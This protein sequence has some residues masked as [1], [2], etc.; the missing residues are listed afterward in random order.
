MDLHLGLVIVSHGANMGPAAVQNCQIGAIMEQKVSPLFPGVSHC[1]HAVLQ[2]AVLINL[3]GLFQQ[4]FPSGVLPCF[5]FIS[6][7]SQLP[8]DP[9]H[10]HTLVYLNK[11]LQIIGPQIHGFIDQAIQ[12]ISSRRVKFI[13]AENTALQHPVG[14]TIE[15]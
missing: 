1:F 15:A 5:V 2:G 10:L 4:I 6:Q 3:F 7:D 11:Q 13:Q 9:V 12:N 14:Q 8:A